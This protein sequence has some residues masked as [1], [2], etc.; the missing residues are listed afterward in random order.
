M[1][2]DI[3]YAAL[4]CTCSLIFGTAAGGT[5]FFLHELRYGPCE[6]MQR[7]DS[8]PAPVDLPVTGVTLQRLDLGDELPVPRFTPINGLASIEE[9]IALGN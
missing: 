9:V 8:L 4:C 2:N 3:K 7:S 5:F 1:W 6:A